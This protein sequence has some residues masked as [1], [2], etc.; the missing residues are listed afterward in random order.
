[1]V[2][3]LLPGFAV[4]A[5]RGGWWTRGARTAFTVLSVSAVAF[6]AWLNAWN[7]LGFRY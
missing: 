6:A 5:S 4:A 3:T 2:A 7:L 1:M